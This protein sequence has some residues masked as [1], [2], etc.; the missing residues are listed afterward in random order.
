MVDGQV[1]AELATDARGDVAVIWYDA[2]RDPAGK[3]LDVFGTVS[4]D[5]GKTFSPNFRI[6]DQSFDPNAGAF[7]DALGNTD[8]FLGQAIGLT[9]AGGTAYAAWTD[10]R[11]GN[12]E[13]Y[14]ASFPVNPPPPPLLDR[15][16]PNNTPTTATDLGQVVS[17][18]L[19]R[20]AT[21][22]GDEG[23][24]RLQAAA[25]G[26]LTVTATLSA[27]GDALRLELF[28]A[29][30]TTLLATGSA[31]FDA[32]GQVIGQTLTS[33]GNAGQTYL[34]RVLPGPAAAPGTAAGYTLD[35]QSLTADLG[36]EVYGVEAGNLA[37]GNQDYYELTPPA[38]GTLEVILTPGA[39]AHGNLHL[40]L[41]DPKTLNSLASGQA[42][43]TALLANL[44]VTQGQMVYL[45]VFGDIGASGDFSL[46][47]TNLDSVSAPNNKTLFFPTGGNPCQVAVADLNARRQAGHR[48]RL[49]RPEHHQRPAEQRGRHLPGP[50]RLCRRCLRGR[51][52]FYL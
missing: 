34:V 43:G 44:T 2:R 32:S 37:P 51:Q 9:V 10:T 25:T 3:L 15:F 23:W 11:N 46:Q 1:F 7:T 49:R 35:V 22:Q 12:Q 42:A 52:L 48:G 29:T 20:L 6:T 50:A 13:I 40:E 38:P 18:H 39:N 47:F 5:G 31:V 14:V 30:G 36:T 16:E 27:P 41:L 21:A 33:P 26:P 19:P 8:D 17:R 24:F 28:D 45:H 4:T